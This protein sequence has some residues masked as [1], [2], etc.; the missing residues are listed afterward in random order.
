[1]ERNILKDISRHPQ[2]VGFS[3]IFKSKESPVYVYRFIG[4]TYV[5]ANLDY[6]DWSIVKYLNELSWE[7]LKKIRNNIKFIKPQDAN[8]WLNKKK[9]SPLL[10][11]QKRL[12]SIFIKE[13]AKKYYL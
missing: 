2:K 4:N 3:I 7:E 8:K 11:F 1:M 12:R 6:L 5:V 10:S 13:A 9:S